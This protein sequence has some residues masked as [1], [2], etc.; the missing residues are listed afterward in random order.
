MDIVFTPEARNDIAYWKR[1]G[2]TAVQHRITAL[3]KDMQQHP[4]TGIGKPERL[5][6]NL[7]GRWSR[8]ITEEHR[9]VYLVTNGIINIISCR[10]HY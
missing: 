5:R 2:N 7:S 1:S 3:L 10:F 8:R 4:Y 6:H 9:I